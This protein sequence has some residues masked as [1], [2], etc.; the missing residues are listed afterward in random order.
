MQIDELQK[1]KQQYTDSHP[2]MAAEVCGAVI[3]AHC[4]QCAAYYRKPDPALTFLLWG[5]PQG[6]ELRLGA[7]DN[8]RIRKHS[9]T[10]A[11]V[12]AASP[13]ACQ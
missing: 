1:L 8:D 4:W 13:G 7:A 12:K 6:I 2:W 5:Q 11:H 3:K 9:K 10:L